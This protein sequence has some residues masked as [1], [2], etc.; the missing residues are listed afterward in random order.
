MDAVVAGARSAG[1]RRLNATLFADNAAMMRLLRDP[2]GSVVSDSIEGGVE[3]I[4]LA[5]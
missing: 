4:V 2:D 3:E 1:L 5:V